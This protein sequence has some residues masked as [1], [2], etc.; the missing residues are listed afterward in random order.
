MWI[1]FH[2]NPY[3]VGGLNQPIWKICSSNWINSPGVKIKNIKK[4]PPRH[5]FHNP[6]PNGGYLFWLSFHHVLIFELPPPAKTTIHPHLWLELWNTSQHGQTHVHLGGKRRGVS[7]WYKMKRMSWFFSG[8]QKRKER[9]ICFSFFSR[10]RVTV[11]KYI[12]IYMFKEC[13]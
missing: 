3:L 6:P 5:G 12:Y 11:T 1:V 2:H 7:W 4:P 13:S 10:H 8:G 9:W